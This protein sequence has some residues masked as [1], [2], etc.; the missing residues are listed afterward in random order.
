MWCNNKINELHIRLLIFTKHRYTSYIYK[1][2]HQ[3]NIIE[4]KRKSF[5]NELDIPIYRVN[6]Q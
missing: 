6:E 4:T 5:N 1:H 2:V 3:N